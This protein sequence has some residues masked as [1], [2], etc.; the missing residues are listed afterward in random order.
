MIT[1]F[2]DL[3]YIGLVSLLA[4]SLAAP[5]MMLPESGFLVVL[6]A[7][8]FPTIL[9]SLKSGTRKKR[10]VIV[11]ILA[12]IAICISMVWGL[13]RTVETLHT[14]TWVGWFLLISV[15]SLVFGFV[16]QRSVTVRRIFA[17]LLVA[18][19]FATMLV[20]G[21]FLKGFS[22]SNPYASTIEGDTYIAFATGRTSA[23]FLW[24]LLLVILVEE[25]QKYWKKS[26][27]TDRKAH[28]VTVAP[29]LLLIVVLAYLLPNSDKPFDWKF[30]K[31]IWNQT[32]IRFEKMESGI[33]RSRDSYPVM[34]F[35]DSGKI[36]GKIGKNDKEVFN[37]SSGNSGTL[38]R[39]GGR[40]FDTFDGHE[41]T[42][43]ATEDA[44]PRVLDTILTRTAVSMADPEYIKDYLCDAR[45]D[46]EY[47]N[48]YSKYMFIPT[49]GIFS[50]TEDISGIEY[51]ESC[52]RLY[53]DKKLGYGSTYQVIYKRLNRDT[54]LFFNLMENPAPV[55]REAWDKSAA[56]LK[57]K[58]GA[59][60][61]SFDEYMAY[62]EAVYNDYLAPVSVSPGTQ[63]IMDTLFDGAVS[64]FD[65]MKR[66]ETWMQTLSYGIDDVEIPDYIATEGEFLDYFLT[67]SRKG[68]CVHYATAFV[69]MARA[70]GLPARYVQGYSVE[71]ATKANI[72]VRESMAHA[73][74]EVYFDNVGWIPFEP[75]PGYKVGSGWAVEDRNY[76]PVIVSNKDYLK[77]MHE[78][79]PVLA[80]E[81]VTEP[82]PAKEKFDTRVIIYPLI[83][84]ILFMILFMAVS[85]II[86]AKRFSKLGTRGKIAE[87]SHRN[88]KMLKKMGYPLKQ[89]QTLE[90]YKK[91]LPESIPEEIGCFTD[92]YEIISYS[93]EEPTEDMLKA[94]AAS[95]ASLRKKFILRLL[96]R[97]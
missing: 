73:W 44:H 30:A 45:I 58:N 21:T 9:V 72:V 88:L 37:L 95:N 56:V 54:D 90:E 7:L 22:A 63:E 52:D 96:H 2:Y 28:L 6:L 43:N 48:F 27:Y 86:A 94:V 83:G 89:G 16:L 91:S 71:T 19:G 69:L 20:G 8:A 18:G 51:H 41:W 50:S 14:N 60:P 36:L 66:L 17:A 53:T 70:Q 47:L 65:K 81:E 84:V 97:R 5:Y 32:V 35:S 49:K 46:I 55:T 80:P 82:E 77:D 92:Y 57:A 31:N 85:R 79:E 11:G 33:F 67:Q 26:G 78:L 23:L 61:Y 25:V 24:A 38:I 42:V 13:E 75:T 76:V 68:Y 40:I 87:L 1:F 34:G 64:D 29:F 12:V 93:E 39:L 4:T 3:I 62:R 59:E 10:L 15:L 74:P